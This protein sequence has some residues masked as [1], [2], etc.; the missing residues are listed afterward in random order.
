MT[1]FPSED[2]IQN[3]KDYNMGFY[4][5]IQCGSFRLC[6]DNDGLCIDCWEVLNIYWW[7]V[8]PLDSLSVYSSQILTP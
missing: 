2:F 7:L 5:C 1:K 6:S 8:S 3:A 4:D